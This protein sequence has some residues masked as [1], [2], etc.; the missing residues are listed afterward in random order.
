[1]Q[2]NTDQNNSEYGHFRQCHRRI[3]NPVEYLQR[4]IFREKT[5]PSQRFHWVLN[6]PVGVVV[7]SCLKLANST[8]KN[9]VISPNF[10]VW[11]FCGKAQFPHSFRRIV[12]Y[13][14][15]VS[16]LLTDFTAKI[17]TYFRVYQTCTMGLHKAPSKIFDR[18]LNTPWQKVEIFYHLITEKYF[19]LNNF[20][21]FINVVP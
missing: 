10:L 6:T 2:K 15:L 21:F 14:I 19:F 1:M 7:F 3:Q 8:A 17:E 13:V 12:N 16:L 20:S 9:T 18:V 11:N 4:S 5:S